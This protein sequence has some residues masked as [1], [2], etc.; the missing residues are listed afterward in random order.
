MDLTIQI[1]ILRHFLALHIGVY[2][3]QRKKYAT[4]TEVMTPFSGKVAL[5]IFFQRT[6]FRCIFHY[7]PAQ[8]FQAI[9]AL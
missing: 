8:V 5:S 9:C 2:E 1:I 6:G 4:Q 3:R 7:P